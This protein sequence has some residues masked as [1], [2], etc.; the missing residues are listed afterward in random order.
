LAFASDSPFLLIYYN[1]GGA[2]YAQ[3]NSN[4]Y[5]SFPSSYGTPLYTGNYDVSIYGVY[6]TTGPTP[7]PTPSPTPFIQYYITVNSTYGSP[8]SSGW[9]T[10]GGT[11][12]VGVTSP[13]TVNNKQ[14]VCLGY[15]IDNNGSGIQYNGTSYSFN[16]VSS[17]HT[18][19]FY[20]QQYPLYNTRIISAS[21]S[22]GGVISP[23]GSIL[24]TLGGSQTFTFTPNVGY[25][26]S[27]VQVNGY[28]IGAVVSYTF[29]NVTSDQS[30]YVSFVSIYSTAKNQ[31]LTLFLRS[32]LY[33]FS[34][35]SG[36]GLDTDYTNNA[37][38]ISIVAGGNGNVTYGF[39]VY[40]LTSSVVSSEL[41]N[42][43]PEAKIYLASNFTGSISS[44]WVCPETS[45][46]LGYQC[47]KV[48]VYT[49]TDSGG[50]WVNQATFITNELTTKKIESS[51]W[52]FTLNVN[53]TT[54]VSAT[55]CQFS[56]G[57]SA[58][59]STVSGVTILT[60][61][62]SD[63]A[64]YRLSIGDLIGFIIGAY[65]DVIGVQAFYVL[66]LFGCCAALYR[67]YT[68]FGVIAVFFILFAGPGG[69]LLL[70]IPTWAVEVAA[71]LM[72]LGCT[73][74]LWRLIK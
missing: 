61:N 30:I 62:N 60:P 19:T 41:T 3:Y 71:L 68:H 1:N 15:S 4:T 36:Y 53:F 24:V 20:W 25:E 14:Y 27:Q 73:F 29:V 72:I 22:S 8:T 52:T 50:N 18:I 44:S 6:S 47:L 49:S 63:L 13:F 66:I 32:D 59:R 40:L 70:F 64:A 35:V 12:S 38:H 16:N 5:G 51:L 7:S 42:G 48:D 17:N 55:N 39:R 23:S 31:N 45:V 69:L 11:Y 43:V 26:I 37:T 21:A 58:Y 46:T 56:F 74:I 33:S 9:V 65:S 67:R 34:G 54:S 2:N 28:S 10:F 57:D